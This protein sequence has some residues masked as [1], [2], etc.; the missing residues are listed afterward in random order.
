MTHNL[1]ATPLCI[2]LVVRDIISFNDVT[3]KVMSGFVILAQST[4]TAEVLL[5]DTV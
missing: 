3:G 1:D 5:H 4:R 2:L